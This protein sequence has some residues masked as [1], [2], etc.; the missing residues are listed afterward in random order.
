M[1]WC[2]TLALTGCLL[3][4]CAAFIRSSQEMLR[5]SH[6]EVLPAEFAQTYSPSELKEDLRFLIQ[7]LE[8]VH[9]HLYAYISETEASQAQGKVEQEFVRPL[10]RI[11]FYFRIAPVVAAFSD[12]HTRIVLPHE[13]YQEWIRTARPVFP[14]EVTV[15]NDSPGPVSMSGWFLKDKSGKVWSLA[16]L[17]SVAAGQ[18]SPVKRNGM[19]MSLNNSGD[20]ITLYDD[21][22]QLRDRFRYTSSRTGQVIRTGH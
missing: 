13:E 6:R 7:T 9:P 19:A 16:G 20:E 5:E 12:G 1:K 11:E 21:T 10:S 15:R 22:N 4:G 8:E 2:W 14:L 18:S 3:C 17:E